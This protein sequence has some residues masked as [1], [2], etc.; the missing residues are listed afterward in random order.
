MRSQIAITTVLVFGLMA[1]QERQANS[2][3][4]T[5][6]DRRTT[7]SNRPNGS[8]PEMVDNDEHWIPDVV[9]RCIDA[10]I[11][12]E[13]IK[14]AWGFNPIYLRVDFDGNDIIDYAILVQGSKSSRNGVLICKDSK[15]PFLFGSIAMS[16]Q[17]LSSFEDDNFVTDRWNINSKEE[18]RNAA[19]DLSGKS[20]IGREAK[21]ESL[22]FYHDGGGVFIFWDGKQFCL[23]QGG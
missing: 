2:A 10:K 4:S 15:T 6:S 18:T 5:E 12:R 11:H 22:G 21:G 17:P 13:Q 20:Q 16:N 8:Q 9:S 19:R 1:C 3:Q 14:P 7:G 23:V